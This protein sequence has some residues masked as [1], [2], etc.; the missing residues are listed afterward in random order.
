MQPSRT[1]PRRKGQQGDRAT[2]DVTQTSPE[3]D[4]LPTQR[5]VAGSEAAEIAEDQDETAG[6]W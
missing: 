3:T 5:E 2:A 4:P 6:W 1:A